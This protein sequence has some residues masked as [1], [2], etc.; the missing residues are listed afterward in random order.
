MNTKHLRVRQFYIQVLD[1]PLHDPKV[2]HHLDKCNE[3][4][5]RGK[6]QL[7]SPM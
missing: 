2:I 3:E 5:N 1:D 7:V 4:N 6:L